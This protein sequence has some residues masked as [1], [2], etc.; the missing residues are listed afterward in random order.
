[1]RWSASV[2]EKY[3]IPKSSTQRENI[4]LRVLCHHRPVVFGMGSYPW[5]Y[6]AL[7]SCLKVSTTDSLIP[8]IP[9][10]ILV[11]TSPLAATS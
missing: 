6:S 3:F 9:L 11:Y 4:V 2:L 5:G 1:M 8:Y 7:T 10:K